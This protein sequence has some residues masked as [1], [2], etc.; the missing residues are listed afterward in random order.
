MWSIII[1]LNPIKEKTIRSSSEFWVPTQA[2]PLDIYT[3]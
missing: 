3:G 1:V 2:G